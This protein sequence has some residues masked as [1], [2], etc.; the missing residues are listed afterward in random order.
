MEVS[1]PS[2][3]WSKLGL[4]KSAAAD[5]EIALDSLKRSEKFEIELIC[6]VVIYKKGIPSAAENGMSKSARRDVESDKLMQS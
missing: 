3:S 2:D 4:T 5:I 6:N 1:S